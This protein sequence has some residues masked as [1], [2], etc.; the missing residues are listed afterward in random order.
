MGKTYELINPS[1]PYTFHAPTFQI[2]SAVGILLG[3]GKTPAH[4]EDGTEKQ[5]FLMFA[6][7]EQVKAYLQETFGVGLNEFIDAH[8]IEIADALESVMSF[9]FKERF[10]F[11]EAMKRIPD[12]NAR[13]AYREQIHD[14]NRSS[15]ND[16]G[17]Y[18]WEVAKNL[19]KKEAKG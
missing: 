17:S 19:R 3:E 8:R 15:L 13:V 4:S 16:F 5:P 11:D 18:A 14:R 10:T 6:T 7:S 12:D 2:A 1:D 9:G